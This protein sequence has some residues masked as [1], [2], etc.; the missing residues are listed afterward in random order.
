MVSVEGQSFLKERTGGPEP[1]IIED[2]LSV[3]LKHGNQVSK[4]AGWAEP[5]RNMRTVLGDKALL[6]EMREK[7]GSDM[8]EYFDRMIGKMEGQ[9]SVQDVMSSVYNRALSNVATGVLGFKPSQFLTQATGWLGLMDTNLPLRDLRTAAAK[10]MTNTDWNS[11]RKYSPQLWDRVKSFGTIEGGIA[12]RGRLLKSVITGKTTVKEASLYPVK[13]G[14]LFVV[15]RAWKAAEDYISRTQPDLVGD[16]KGLAIAKAAEIAVHR[17]QSSYSVKDRSE[18]FA[19]RSPI[20]KS[21]TFMGSQVARQASQ[22]NRSITRFRYNPTPANGARIIGSI[23]NAGVQSYLVALIGV[24]TAWAKGKLKHITKDGKID[25]RVVEDRAAANLGA[26]M[27]GGTPVGED[28]T[29]VMVKIARE[30]WRGIGR[31]DIEQFNPELVVTK[32]LKTMAFAIK[33]AQRKVEY[34]DL[35]DTSRKVIENNKRLREDVAGLASIISGYDVSE[36]NDWANA[37]LFY[38]EGE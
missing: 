3:M 1:L 38:T 34:K 28:L 23:V 29:R 5:L 7:Y 14:D 21:I 32:I 12:A 2:A 11:I 33:D 25:M 4:Y 36:L 27:S 18:L 10:P 19:E 15:G 20:V 6:K 35:D 30:G 13:Y 24:L 37:L 26:V 9:E 31:Q 8:P 16:Q 22:I 17:S